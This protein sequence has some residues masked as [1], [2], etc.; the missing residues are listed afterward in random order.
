[1]VE[2]RQKV[3]QFDVNVGSEGVI[4]Y[5]VQTSD[6]LGHAQNGT[7]PVE[8]LTTS[9]LTP[10]QTFTSDT[11]VKVQVTN[12]VAGGFT[13]TIDDPANTQI[14]VPDVF[15]LSPKL[16]AQIIQAAGL[17]PKFTGT[18]TKTSWVFSQ[19]PLAGHLVPAGSIVTMVLHTGPVQ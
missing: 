18:N 7:A 15:Q 8:L 1:M 13:V 3:D 5:Q 4:V 14:A 17:V 19:S 16:A 9:A 10:G 11:G 6:S 2:A 12:A